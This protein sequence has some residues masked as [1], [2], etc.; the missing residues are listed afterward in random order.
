[1][2][3]RE[4]FTDSDL[5]APHDLRRKQILAA[6]HP[7]DSAGKLC[8]AYDPNFELSRTIFKTLPPGIKQFFQRTKL[9]T[10]LQ[11]S[12]A[13]ISEIEQK[14]ASIGPLPPIAD[15]TPIHN[16]MLDQCDFSCE[17]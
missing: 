10:K 2:P 17:Q 14:Y 9:D 8:A 11:W 12:E 13:A 3:S 16:F 1:M 6:G 15:D 7:V 4:A 5:V